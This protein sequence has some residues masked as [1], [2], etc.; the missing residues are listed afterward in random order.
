MNTETVSKDPEVLMHSILQRVATGPDL[1]KSISYDEAREGM[2]MVLDR[3]TS[4]MRIGLF[5]IALRMKR[6]TDAENT[7]VLQ[8]ILDATQTVVAAVDEVIDIADPYD[9]YGRTLPSSVFLPAVLAACDVAAVCHGLEAVGPKYGVTNRKVL[10]AAGYDV[11]MSVEQAAARL[12]GRQAGWA[13]VDQAASCP[14]LHDLVGLRSEMVKRSV[15]TTAEVL[16]GPIRG[17]NKTH[18]V[19]GYVHKPYPPIYANL[20]R[21]SG[22]DSALLVRGVEGGVIPSLRQPGRAFHFSGEGELEGK[23]FNPSELDIDQPVRAVPFPDGI[24]LI[25]KRGSAEA[26]KPDADVAAGM[27]ATLGMAALAGEAGA[28]R[29]GLVYSGGMCLWHLGRVDTIQKG[30]EWVRSVLDSGAALARFKD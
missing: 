6:E 1:S 30:A 12:D 18:L 20:A 15:V 9:G 26:D 24:P 5:L 7:G 27:A 19:T 25:K 3:E 4:D 10:R 23:D 28:F 29:D 22:F 17:R 21:H 13:Y 8:A 14:K 2:R 11:D 16:T